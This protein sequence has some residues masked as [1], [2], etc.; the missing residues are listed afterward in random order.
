M[1]GKSPTMLVL[2]LVLE[3]QLTRLCHSSGS[4]TNVTSECFKSMLP[5]SQLRPER[6]RK[7]PSKLHVF[8]TVYYKLCLFLNIT[9]Q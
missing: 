2:A 1:A 6:E 9:D 7:D 3:L 5:Y 4:E 8:M